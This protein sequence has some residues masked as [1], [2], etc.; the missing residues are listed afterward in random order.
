VPGDSQDDGNPWNDGEAPT[1]DEVNDWFEFEVLSRTEDEGDLD[2]AI[3]TETEDGILIRT[4]DKAGNQNIYY[5]NGED[6]Y[7][8]SDAEA[9]NAPPSDG[10]F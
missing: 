3:K 7:F 5:T 8:T 10:L 6:A 9:Y 2:S 4:T 1:R